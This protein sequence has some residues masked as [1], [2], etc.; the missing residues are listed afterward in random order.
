MWPYVI[1]DVFT[2]TPLEGNPLAVFTE[3]DGLPPDRM[4]RVA[5][6]MNLSETVF[7]LPPA[8]GG[9][10]RIRIFTPS[11]ELPFAGHPTFGSA[12]VLCAQRGL[13][14]IGLE[15]GAGLI[16]VQFAGRDGLASPQPADLP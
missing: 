4:Q 8:A 16:R 10:A 13:D 7:V 14:A 2:G 6:E 9:D 12:F 1:V 15:T 5:R 11:T 3:A